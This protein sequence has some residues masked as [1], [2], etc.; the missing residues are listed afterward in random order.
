M[1][2]SVYTTN[3]AKAISEALEGE[4]MVINFE[5]GSYYNLNATA[6]FLWEQ[7]RAGRTIEQLTHELQSR[8]DVGADAAQAAVAQVVDFLK[9]ESLIVETEV[10]GTAEAYTGAKTPFA[11]PIVDKY[12]DMQEMLLADPI[13]DVD[14]AGWPKLKPTAAK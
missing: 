8:F 11:A 4:V 14:E 1:K 10:A 2:P 5:T 7:L 6:A 3:D 12:D 9:Q 13:H